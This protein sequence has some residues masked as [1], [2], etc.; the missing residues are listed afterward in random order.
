MS[1]Y[2][3]FLCIQ[4]KILKEN[5]YSFF[6]EFKISYLQSNEAKYHT[7]EKKR[8]NLQQHKLL[9]KKTILLIKSTSKYQVT[10][11]Y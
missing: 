3:K 7:C 1:I 8:H 11:R 9:K 6:L 4:L 5:N 2:I 10:Y